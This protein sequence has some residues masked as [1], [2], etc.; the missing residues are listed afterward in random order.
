MNRFQKMAHERN[1]MR[2]AIEAD[3]MPSGL[4][5]RAK[6]TLWERAWEYGHSAGEAEV[7]HYYDDIADVLRAQFHEAN[8]STS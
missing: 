3:L 2:E 7:R 6:D 4:T 5:Q 1:Q 8:P